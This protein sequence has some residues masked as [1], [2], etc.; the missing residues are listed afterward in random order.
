M[1]KAACEAGPC[2]GPLNCYGAGRC[3]FDAPAS[4]TTSEERSMNN[5]E[6]VMRLVRA[7]AA[8]VGL[9]RALRRLIAAEREF[10]RDTGIKLDDLIT[11]AV[12]HAEIVLTQFKDIGANASN[13][14][15][16]YGEKGSQ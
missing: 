1:T 9:R 12:Q 7:E 6:L 15:S 14:A 13:A 3:V 10:S 11:E 16:S 2:P 8:V 4:P 5:G